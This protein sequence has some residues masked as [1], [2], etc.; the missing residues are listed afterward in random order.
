MT[1]LFSLFI[2]WCHLQT[3]IIWLHFSKFHPTLAHGTRTSTA[4]WI[5]M[6][7]VCILA[8]FQNLVEVLP[9]SPHVM[10][11]RLWVSHT[12]SWLCFFYSNLVRIFVVEGCCIFM[13]SLHLWESHTVNREQYSSS[14][15]NAMAETLLHSY[16]GTIHQ[17]I[18]V[19]IEKMSQPKVTYW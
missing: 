17:T 15:K 16:K 11:S 10:W 7:E 12:L 6:L 3:G 9:I 8:W 1:F 5:A 4:D 14:G 2:R 13:F 19:F 18:G